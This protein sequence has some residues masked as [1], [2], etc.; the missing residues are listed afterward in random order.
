MRR[1]T[2]EWDRSYTFEAAGRSIEKHG[3][4]YGARME[5]LYIRITVRVYILELRAQAAEASSR[6]KAIRLARVS[7]HKR[8]G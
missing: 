8:A 4:V 2:K 3:R 5:R 1:R 6:R 7:L